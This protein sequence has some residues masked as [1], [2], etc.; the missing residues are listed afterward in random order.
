MCVAAN[1]ILVVDWLASYVCYASATI[2]QVAIL[3]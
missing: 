2:V 1:D 3:K